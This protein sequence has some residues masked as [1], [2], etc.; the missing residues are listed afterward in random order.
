[1]SRPT[2]STLCLAAVLLALP[3]VAY[4]PA[5]RGDFVWDDGDYVTDNLALRSLGGLFKIWFEMGATIQY[6]PLTFT[7]FWIEYQLW[8]LRPLG[9]HLVNVI[10]HGLTAVLLWRT[11]HRLKMPG[12]WL[13]AAIFVVHPVHVESVAWI[14]E[15]KNTLSGLFALATAWALVRYLG[16]D[17]EENR[18][19]QGN[20]QADRRRNRR[21]YWL[22]LVLFA[23]ALL[24]KSAVCPLPAAV[25]AVIWWKRGRIDRRDA[26]SMAPFLAL[27]A[28][29]ALATTWVERT[30]VGASEM[31]WT[32]TWLQ[33]GLLAPRSICFYLVKVIWPAGTCFIYPR[34]QIDPTVWWQYLFP[35][36]LLAGL[37]GLWALRQRIGRG[38]L[39]AVSILI[40]MVLPTLGIVKFYF[41][42]YSFVADHF[43][44][45]GSMGPIALLAAFLSRGWRDPTATSALRAHGPS[46]DAR[47]SAAPSLRPAAIS[48]ALHA[49]PLLILGALTWHSAARFSHIETLWRRT[50]AAN[51]DA[52]MALNNLGYYLLTHDRAA[53]AEPFFLQAIERHPDHGNARFNLASILANRGEIDE[54][55]TQLTRGLQSEPASPTA[56]NNLG[57]LLIRKG[58][59]AESLS[60]FREAVRLKPDFALA[61]CNI[62]VALVALGAPS[63][64]LP[65][66]NE[67]LRL[68]G[69]LPAAHYTLAAALVDLQRADE[70]LP[71]LLTAIRLSPDYAEAHHDLAVLLAERGRIDEAI[72]HFH[73]TIRIS[74]EFADA[75]FNLARTLE[76]AGR[77]VEAKRAYHDVLRIN[78]NDEEARRALGVID[79]HRK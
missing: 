6:Y 13:A 33:R 28:L 30:T 11:L 43:Q 71:H 68:D 58:R 16:L 25:L 72:K 69:A 37:L 31:A 12:A 60:H 21:F 26:L 7:S 52:W 54:A 5:I 19:P 1:M 74:P 51:P 62:G 42:T 2:I 70:A 4:L 41:M 17:A 50:I 64:A 45:L 79:S 10:L 18:E 63:D 32:L 27:S 55:I 61:H 44:Y 75:H 14:T 22:A 15:R 36:A 40:I 57:D 56:H 49:A 34:W 24:S 20:H 29:M 66:L 39:A 8:G 53:E 48:V 23:A 65:S 3:L 9:Y 73:E 76:S 67:A 78:P 77:L 38:P 46:S 35:L 47:P 59:L